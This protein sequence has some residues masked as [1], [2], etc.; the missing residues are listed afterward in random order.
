MDRE[1]TCAF[2]FEL[3]ACSAV[4]GVSPSGITNFARQYAR[5]FKFILMLMLGGVL[6]GRIFSISEYKLKR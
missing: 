2:I 6:H 5:Q 4:L 1:N 3:R